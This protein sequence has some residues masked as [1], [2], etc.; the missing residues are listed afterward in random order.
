MV[1]VLVWG[2]AIVVFGFADH[3]WLAL[4][5]LAVAGAGDMV[6]GIFRTAILRASVED[7]VRGRLDGIGMA[8]WA[9]G[10]AIGNLESGAVAQVAGVTSSIV[11]GGILTILGIG[12]LHRFA[13]GFWHYDAADPSP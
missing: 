9:G 2:A 10:P 12:A 5:M 3:L 6:S 13:P 8:V 11:S 4:A 7:R 1:A